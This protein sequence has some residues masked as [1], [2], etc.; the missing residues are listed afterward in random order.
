MTLDNA[1]VLD[2]CK[3]GDPKAQEELYKAFAPALLGV[4]MRY[5][6]SRDDAQD[7]LHDAFIKILT[8]IKQVQK[9]EALGAWMNRIMVSTV[10]GYFRRNNLVVY[11]EDDSL[12]RLADKTDADTTEIVEEKEQNKDLDMDQ[13]DIKFVM[14]AI[15]RLQPRYRAVFNM[16]AVEEMEY[17]DIARELGIA[18]V[19]ARSHYSYARRI[20]RQ[21]LDVGIETK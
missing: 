7:L 17:A 6:H 11:C 1:Q 12:E 3:R 2:A 19:T 8:N 10:V 4:G 20:L 18:E 9:P 16:R 21:F 14:K 5:L 15:D 13:Y